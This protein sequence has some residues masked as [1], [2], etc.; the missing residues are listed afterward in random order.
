MLRNLK[1]LSR[2]RLV[3]DKHFGQEHPVGTDGDGWKVFL[4]HP[5]HVE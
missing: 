3:V 4:H 1:G 2:E 5:D